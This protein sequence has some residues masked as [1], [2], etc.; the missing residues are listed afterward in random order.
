MIKYEVVTALV[1]QEIVGVIKMD[2]INTRV[3]RKKNMRGEHKV[4]KG[5]KAIEYDFQSSDLDG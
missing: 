2:Q 3:K 5:T 1:I 4:E